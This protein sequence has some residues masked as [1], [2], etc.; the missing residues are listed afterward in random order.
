LSALEQS[1][2][3]RAWVR[4]DGDEAGKLVV[5]KFRQVYATSW[6]ENR[7]A[8]FE[9]SDFE[10]YYPANFRANVEETLAIDDK[11]LKRKAKKALLES[12]LS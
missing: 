2:R 1:Y 8:C 9:H 4:A 11:K 3:N 7:F 12:V 10:S 5:Q 6:D